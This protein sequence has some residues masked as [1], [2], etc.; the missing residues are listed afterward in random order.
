MSIATVVTRGFGT[1]GS[2]NFVT[3]RGFT[4]GAAIVSSDTYHIITGQQMIA[5]NVDTAF[6][7]DV[8]VDDTGGVTGLTI[9]A[10]IR[11]SSDNTS[12][13]DFDDDTFKTSG[14]TS[15]TTAL[16]EYGSGFYGTTIDITAIT[17][18]PSGSH[19]SVEYDVSGTITAI[20]GDVITFKPN[21]RRH[22]T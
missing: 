22:I 15:K 16:T 12:Y 2:V 3:T 13:L 8:T 18:L 5:T 1:F 21:K 20:S 6:P 19:L 17:N 9:T 10:S 4:V 11:D 14:W 7:L